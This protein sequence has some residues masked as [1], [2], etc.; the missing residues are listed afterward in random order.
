MSTAAMS[1]PPPSEPHPARGVRVDRIPN[2]PPRLVEGDRVAV[3]VWVTQ[4]GRYV[5]DADLRL[6]RSEASAL[7]DQLAG[8]LASWRSR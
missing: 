7:R 6:S 4:D 5:G 8:A 1:D 3:P 2:R